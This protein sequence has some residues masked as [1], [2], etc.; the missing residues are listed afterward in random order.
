LCQHADIANTAVGFP[1]HT[2]DGLQLSRLQQ[3]A[4]GLNSEQLAWA[5]G[6]L[7]ELYHWLQEGAQL[8]VCGGIAMEHAVRQSLQGIVQAQGGLDEAAA[9]ERLPEER[10]GDFVIRQGLV[11]AVNN[12]AEDYHATG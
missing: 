6:Y 5:S 10:F 7:A 9:D 2:L 8:Y 12:P 1:P 4:D 11:K 3:A